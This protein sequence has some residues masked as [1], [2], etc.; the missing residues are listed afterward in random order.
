MDVKVRIRARDRVDAKPA[1]TAAR[2]K[3]PAKVKAD[4]K[5]P[6]TVAK[7]RMAVPPVARS[8]SSASQSSRRENNLPFFIELRVEYSDGKLFV[9]RYG[10]SS[11]FCIEFHR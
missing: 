5:R 11:R 10:T 4:V 9:D 7:E 6:K 2:A 3:I 8:S 1:I